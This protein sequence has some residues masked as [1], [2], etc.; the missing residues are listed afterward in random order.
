[1]T[2]YLD[3]VTALPAGGQRRA[4]VEMLIEKAIAFENSSYRGLF[5]FIRYIEKLQKYDVDFGE[6]EIVSENDE[7]VRIMSIHKSKGLEFP[8]ALWQD[9]ENVLICRTVMEKSSYIRSLGSVWKSMIRK[10]G[11]SRSPL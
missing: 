10:G 7:A 8:I 1:M 11:S 5:H 6:A 4:N 2:G 9:W 3:Y